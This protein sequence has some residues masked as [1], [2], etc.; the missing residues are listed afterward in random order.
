MSGP[1]DPEVPDTVDTTAAP[2]APEDVSAA[3]PPRGSRRTRSAIAILLLAALVAAGLLLAL[4]V[5]NGN[6][7]DDWRRRSDDQAATIRSLQTVLET[8]SSQLNFRIRQVNKLTASI[9]RSQN[10][11]RRSESDVSSLAS[12][13]RELADEKA[14]VEDERSQL[15][16]EAGVLE[17]IAAQFQDCSTGLVDLLTYVLRE[18]YASAS[19]I[20]DSVV[21]ECNAADD[22]LSAYQAQYG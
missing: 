10:A 17:G 20:A 16:V 13:Q 15:Q 4:S 7:A 2:L 12:R 19:A 1:I 18:D 5:R 6:R 21:A 3:G 8:R 9:R 22:G 14:Q 11:L